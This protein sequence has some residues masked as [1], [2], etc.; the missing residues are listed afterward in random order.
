MSLKENSKSEKS[1]E[2]S[3]FLQNSDTKQV[4]TEM[5]CFGDGFGGDF[6]R[7]QRTYIKH[8]YISVCIKT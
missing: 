6:R 8:T 5:V 2:A 4:G 3:G 1:V 7:L